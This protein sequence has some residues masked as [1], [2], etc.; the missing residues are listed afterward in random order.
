MQGKRSKAFPKELAYHH[1]LAGTENNLAAKLIQNDKAAQARPMLLHAV[2][3]LTDAA[4][5]D[6]KNV[7]TRHLLYV[8]HLNLAAAEVSLG[9]HQDVARQDRGSVRQVQLRRRPPSYQVAS[10]GF[11]ARC[12]PLAEKD[13]ALPGDKGKRCEELRRPG[14]RHAQASR[15][16]GIQGREDAQGVGGLRSDTL[17]AG[18]SANSA[19]AG[20]SKRTARQEE[21]TRSGRDVKESRMA[22]IHAGPPPTIGK[23][24]LS[25][26]PPCAFLRFCLSYRL[27]TMA[28][29]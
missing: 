13:K 1:D 26:T 15:R 22:A 20:E 9:L 3:H 14:H 27:P 18:V 24:G 5:L 28:K 11:M 10:A 7:Q 23:S 2:A 4:A 17:V 21:M 8:S 19:D 6:V 25:S 12:V 16:Q 29:K